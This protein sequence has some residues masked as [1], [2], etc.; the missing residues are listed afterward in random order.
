MLVDEREVAKRAGYC[1]KY[2]AK[3]ADADRQFI[4][5]DTGE[6]VSLRCRAWSKSA[7]WGD[8]MRAVEGRRRV[9]AAG[10]VSAGRASPPG[11]VRPALPLLDLNSDC[12]TTGA[13][14]VVAEVSEA[15]CSPV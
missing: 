2:A 3:M 11:G 14:G 13:L 10:A 8:A 4:N 6:I 15:D 1:S 5:P 9:W 7:R 12:Y